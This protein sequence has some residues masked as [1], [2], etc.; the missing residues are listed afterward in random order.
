M[1][2]TRKSAS[3]TLA[4]AF[5]V[6]AGAALAGDV[7]IPLKADKESPAASGT[8]F[9]GSGKIRVQA[10]GLHPDGVYTVWFVN[11]KPKKQE[12]GAGSAPYAFRTDGQ[13]KGSYESP[14]VGVALRQVGHDHGR[15]PSHR[16]SG[17]HEEHGAGALG[18]NPH[19]AV[20]G[21]ARRRR[22][23]PRRLRPTQRT[24]LMALRGHRKI[25]GWI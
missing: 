4:L 23:P 12:A 19:E 6:I 24:N 14:P 9:L 5:L 2:V 8:A 13:G 17:R 11:M 15:A 20:G 22:S 1:S 21:T 3:F 10:E 16:R 18:W 7:S 25:K